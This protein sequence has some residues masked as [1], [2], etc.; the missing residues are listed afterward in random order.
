M[1]HG[2]GNADDFTNEELSGALMRKQGVR[3]IQKPK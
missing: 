2:F 3:G 1:G